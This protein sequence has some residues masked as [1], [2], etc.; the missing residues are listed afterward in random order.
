ME[1]LTMLERI[2]TK[3]LQHIMD[4]IITK[5]HTNII[6][7]T[8]P[9]RC[10]LMQSSCVNSEIKS[11]NRKLKKMVKVYQCTSVLEMDNDRKLFTN[12][13]LHLNGQGKEVLSKLIVSL[14]YSE[15]EQTIGRPVI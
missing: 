2:T 13:S 12:H 6:L 11:F 7:V 5:N 1:V 4:F 10:D 9:P 14:T 8:V 3:A 15:L